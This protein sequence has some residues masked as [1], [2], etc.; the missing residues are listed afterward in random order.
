[1]RDLLH[2]DSFDS[3]APIS[4]LGWING[5]SRKP[6][7]ARAESDVRAL[8]AALGQTKVTLLNQIHGIEIYNH[9]AVANNCADAILIV[10]DE[11]K[12]TGLAGIRTADCVPLMLIAEHGAC[13]VHAGWR[14]L[15]AGL[16]ERSLD[17]LE[18]RCG[19]LLFAAIG[20]CAGATQYEVGLDVVSAIA[21]GRICKAE[22][23][24]NGKFLLDLK[25]TV[26]EIL[27]TKLQESQLWVSPIC[28]I[29][30][31]DYHSHRRD[32]ASA[33]RNLTFLCHVGGI[34]QLAGN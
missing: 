10:T 12:S 24:S 5:F 2:L 30:S 33:G 34:T 20:P 16:V 7:D 18:R 25:S 9:D 8:A 23:S 29:S 17:I 32:G 21:Q 6:F 14:G 31:P 22:P 28:T 27:L 19:K 15:A 1:M 3:V 11:H 4:E 13:L 26:V